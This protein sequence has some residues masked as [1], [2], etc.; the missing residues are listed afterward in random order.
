MLHLSRNSLLPMCP[1][2]CS[3]NVLSP[4]QEAQEDEEGLSPD[5]AGLK[6]RFLGKGRQGGLLEK[7]VPGTDLPSHSRG[8]SFLGTQPTSQGGHLQQVGGNLAHHP[9]SLG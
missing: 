1:P 4:C 3:A 8:Y 9:D 2:G 5:S 6:R 7:A